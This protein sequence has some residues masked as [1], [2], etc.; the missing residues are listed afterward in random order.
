MILKNS[1]FG[2]FQLWEKLLL[3][4]FSGD[5]LRLRNGLAVVCPILFSLIKMSNEYKCSISDEIKRNKNYQNYI[6]MY[7][8]ILNCYYSLNKYHSMYSITELVISLICF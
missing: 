4:Y 7:N 8:R 3:F 2:V 1:T 6:K 5:H